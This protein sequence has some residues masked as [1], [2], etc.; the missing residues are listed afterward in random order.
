MN[1]IRLNKL[2][3]DSFKVFEVFECDLDSDFIVL[4][5]PNGFG[6]TSVYDAL[7][8][9]FSK[10]I[11]R[12]VAL[13]KAL[14]INAKT[15][16][17]KNL[18]QNN[19]SD[20]EIVIK[21]EFIKG[22]EKI[23]MMRK[24]SK[25]DLMNKKNHKPTCFEIF[26]LYSLTSYD[27]ESTC[28]LINDETAYIA[29]IF[30]ENFLSNFSILNY[31]SQGN[32]PIIIPDES[33]GNDS[34][35]DQIK[36][37]IKLDVIDSKIND[38][39]SSIKSLKDSLKAKKKIITSGTLEFQEL[40]KRLNTDLPSI[41]YKRLGK[42][43]LV[44]QWDKENPIV[45]SSQEDRS[46]ILESIELLSNI[47]EHKNEIG[48][49]ERNFGISKFVESGSLAVAVRLGE[50]LDSYSDLLSKNSE[51]LSLEYQISA[52]NVS[53]QNLKKAHLESLSKYLSEK[54]INELGTLISQRDVVSNEIDGAVK[55]QTELNLLRKQIIDKISEMEGDE[56]SCPLCGFNYKENKLLLDAVKAKTN[57]IE[58][59]ITEKDASLKIC[60]EKLKAL[61]DPLKEAARLNLI[62]LNSSHNSNLFQDLDKN[63]GKIDAIRKVVSRLQANGI[64]LEKVYS[65]DD[66]IQKDRLQKIKNK[67][68]ELKQKEN[69]VL[70]DG[71]FNFYR[72][73]FVKVEFILGLELQDAIDKK[74]Y[75][76]CKYNTFVNVELVNKKE[77]VQKLIDDNETLTLL[78]EKLDKVEKVA[79]RVRNQYSSETIGQM[80]SL[81]HLYSGRLIQ[82][83]Q[84]GLGLFIDT[85]EGKVSRKKKVLSF[86]T[87]DGTKYDA[88]LSM[89]SGQISALTLSFF[90]SLNRKYAKTSF[91]LIDD[92]TQSMDEI[93]IASLSDLLRVELKNRQ[94]IISTHEQEVSEYLR[95]RYQRAGL[96]SKSIHMQKLSLETDVA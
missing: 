87:A 94:V 31:M 80:E 79:V 90:L 24:A 67:I 48:N 60:I 5:G 55:K 61:K 32:N 28:E 47:I 36:H 49:R 43:D 3:I 35:F 45:S 91:I 56:S 74:Q 83:Y 63:T 52:L 72:N 17:G 46:N 84:R 57:S 66:V 22:N 51:K 11:P 93:N 10:S 69:D 82:N 9:L 76:E 18:Y 39:R 64:Q 92:P 15:E 50:H 70:L 65:N 96:R 75:V 71:A 37:L 12:I 1:R 2:S 8:L 42:A 44:F 58:T 30:G 54:I 59:L 73:N 38:T 81:F 19:N 85:D 77:K 86:F 13:N 53:E 41:K 4:D 23:C 25:E 68:I 88:T 14:K 26:K 95:Y 40:E 89:S 7:Q 27:E 16:Y 62:T 33:N 78:I 34:R 6:K 20:R 21:A 29:G